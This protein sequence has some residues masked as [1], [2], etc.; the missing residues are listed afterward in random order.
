MWH[1][2]KPHHPQIYNKIHNTH[3][4]IW[5]IIGVYT[6]IKGVEILGY[7]QHGGITI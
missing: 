5:W 6:L 7:A 3:M 2:S 1:S 4:G